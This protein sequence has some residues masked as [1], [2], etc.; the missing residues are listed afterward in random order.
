MFSPSH[1]RDL[2]Q[3]NYCERRVWLSTNKPDLAIPDTDFIQMIQEKGVVAEEAHVKT[4]GPVETPEYP[5]FEFPIGFEETCKMIKSKVLV[6]YQ[7]VLISNNKQWMAV[8]DLLIFDKKTKKYILRDVKLARNLAAHPEIDLGMG[9]CRIIAED[10]LGYQP[11]IEVA[12]GDGEVLSPYLVPE[13]D[14]VLGCIE[15]IEKLRTL[16][17]EP[18]EMAG[19]SKCNS[20]EFFDH[21]WNEAWEGR[22]ICTISGI[23]QGMSKALWSK[24]IKTWEILVKKANDIADVTFQRGSQTQRIGDTRADKIIRQARCL[25]KN[26]HEKIATIM[27]PNG[28]TPGDRPIVIFD[29]ENNMPA[30]EELDLPVDVY[31]WGLMVVTSK[32]MNQQLVIAPK[33]KNGDRK[34]WQLFLGAM[35]EIFNKYG[36]IPII[37]FSAHEKTKVSNYIANYGD[38]KS[39]GQRVLNNLWDLYRATLTSVVLPVPSYGLKQVEAFVGFKRSQEEYGGSWSIVRYNQ[40]L[41]ASTLIE[42]NAILK[43]IKTY[44]GEDLM[45][46]YEVFK[47]VEEHCC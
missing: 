19:W 3:P 32:K 5:Q 39:V 4:I 16:P 35:T 26:K 14:E 18:M 43:E 17:K 13:R 22:Y 12:K 29:V 11:V 46:T 21:C 47:W 30:F 2:F 7:G 41:E 20:C 38:T 6:I 37:H 23:E 25:S 45:A 28:Y 36:D 8:P 1:F 31:L 27:L 44:N 34:G 9:L 33:G 10:V 40:Y 15:L 42:A 24:K